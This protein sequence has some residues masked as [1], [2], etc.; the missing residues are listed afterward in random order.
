[1]TDTRKS[2]VCLSAL[3]HVSDSQSVYVSH[4]GKLRPLRLACRCTQAEKGL[5]WG[6]VSANV[7]CFCVCLHCLRGCVSTSQ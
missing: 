7:L 4:S 3:D 6:G 1:M 2:N 5:K